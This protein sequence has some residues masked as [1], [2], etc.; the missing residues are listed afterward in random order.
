MAIAEVKAWVKEFIVG[1][2]IC[3][4]AK[5]P[6]DR[7]QIQYLESKAIK[8]DELLADF[9]NCIEQLNESE[10][11]TTS[12]LIYSKC[13]MD[14]LDFNDFAGIL[15]DGLAEI[16]LSEQ[17]QIVVFHP[18]FYF[19][20]TSKHSPANYVNR[21]PYPMIHILNRSDVQNA[22]KNFEQAEQISYL[23]EKKIQNMTPQEKNRI[24]HFL[25]S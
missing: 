21:S 5:D 25:K 20:D 10:H 22:L 2:N 12:L 14:F 17:Y 8:Q 3:P 15:E 11:H 18:G 23:N 4:F 1:M 13:D 19:G 6:F 9:I 16:N 24:F 7:N